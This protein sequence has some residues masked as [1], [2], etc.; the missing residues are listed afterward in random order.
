M[1]VCICSAIYQM[2]QVKGP[3]VELADFTDIPYQEGLNR[4]S[5]DCVYDLDFDGRDDIFW[6]DQ[7]YP[8]DRDGEIPFVVGCKIGDLR[9]RLDSLDVKELH[10]FV[11]ADLDQSDQCCDLIISMTQGAD[12]ARKT[13]VVNIPRKGMDF[14]WDTNRPPA[15]GFRYLKANYWHLRE[16][17]SKN[18]QN[19]LLDGL[20][21]GINGEGAL[22]IGDLR[23][24]PGRKHTLLELKTE[25][26]A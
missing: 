5:E 18:Q 26:T 11:L 17:N 19:C 7:N 15:N 22:L 21:Q 1:G 8:P 4:M 23:L 6:F 13:L 14:P 16:I 24:K 20:Y 12:N 2:D 3:A 9:V 10:A 25:E